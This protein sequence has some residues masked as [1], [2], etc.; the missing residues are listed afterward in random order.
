MVEVLESNCLPAVMPYAPQAPLSLAVGAANRV[1]MARLVQTIRKELPLVD[2]P[3]H[4][5]FSTPGLYRRWMFVPAGTIVVGKIHKHR[6]LFT[7]AAGECE[8]RGDG[9][10]KRLVAPQAWISEPGVQRA[11]VAITDCVFAAVHVT[12]S[13]DPNEIEAEF[14]AQDAL[15]YEQFLL[16]NRT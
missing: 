13:T 5:D 9:T 7:M 3:V 14:I 4:H 6:N 8:F 15:E 11:V 10:R 12:D 2:C 1:R 16:E